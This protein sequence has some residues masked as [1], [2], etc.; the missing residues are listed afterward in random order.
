MATRSKAEAKEAAINYLKDYSTIT[1]VV[2]QKKCN[3]YGNLYVN[4][5]AYNEPKRPAVEKVQK[6]YH[7]THLLASMLGLKLSADMS[8]KVPD[9][10]LINDL[11]YLKEAFEASG[12]AH[13]NFVLLD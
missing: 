4:I 1:I 3:V 8:V 12:L 10:Y 11:H 5:K 13:I 9:T 6:A 2:V 7:C